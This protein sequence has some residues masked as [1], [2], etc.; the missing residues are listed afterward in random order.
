MNVNIP[1]FVT[2]LL[3]MAM[4]SMSLSK[5]VG[6]KRHT[7]VQPI[8]QVECSNGVCDTTYIYKF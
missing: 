8:I 4:I 5:M 3:L 7:P 2:G 1:A 6:Y